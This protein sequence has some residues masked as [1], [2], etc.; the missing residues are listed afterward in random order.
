MGVT[1][2]FD[3]PSELI[4]PQEP[5]G[6]P[7][8]VAVVVVH[9]LGDWTADS[10]AALASQDYPNLQILV[11]STSQQTDEAATA[12]V[13][14]C[15][16]NA[17]ASVLRFMDSNPGFGAACNNVLVMVDGESGFYLFIHDDAV[18]AADGVSRLIE[19]LYRSNAGIVGPKIVSWDDVR[20]LQSVGV[21]VDRF[22]ERDSVVSADEIDQ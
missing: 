21:A 1:E 7:P 19:E 13:D 4:A 10:L 3:T 22:G 5:V 9:E 8:V 15:A 14:V 17:P 6:V 20:Q 11:L 12:I 18:L 16:N 2:F